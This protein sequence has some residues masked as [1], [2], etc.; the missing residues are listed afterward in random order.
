MDPPPAEKSAHLQSYCS[1][2]GRVVD[3]S[4]RNAL[5][6]NICAQSVE[7]LNEHLAAANDLHT[8]VKQSHWNV[9]GPGFIAIH[10]LFDKV[11]EDI[12]G[13]SDLLAERAAGLGGTARGAV[14]GGDDLKRGEA[15]Q[16]FKAE[17]T[18]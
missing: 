4:T 3:V 6:E 5:S 9:R 11:A 7:L 12:E 1:K 16:M 18:C 2:T 15:L 8:Q 13:Y 10:E 17:L 14:H